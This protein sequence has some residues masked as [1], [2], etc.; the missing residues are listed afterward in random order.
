M[1]DMKPFLEQ[2]ADLDQRRQEARI[3]SAELARRVGTS[4]AT[5]SYY[6]RGSRQPNV[7]KWTRINATLEKII[8][9]RAE[10]L[11]GMTA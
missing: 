9:E 4:E 11:R 10:T 5:L 1:P 8:A 3:S 7:D 2:M 6:R